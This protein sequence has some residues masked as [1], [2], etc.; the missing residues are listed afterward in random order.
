MLV[1]MTLGETQSRTLW[2]PT[3]LSAVFT[4][5]HKLFGTFQMAQSQVANRSTKD[6]L[7]TPG[8]PNES[9]TLT[10]HQ[11]PEEKAWAP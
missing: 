10:P 5:Q 2:R 8:Q 3:V 4:C 11:R 1:Q 9:F 6:H 7:T